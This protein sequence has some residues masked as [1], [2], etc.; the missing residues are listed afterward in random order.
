MKI[1][2]LLNKQGKLWLN[3]GSSY[4]VLEDYI[5][6]D[7]SIFLLMSPFYPLLKFMLKSGHRE[8]IERF[9]KIKASGVTMLRCNCLKPLPFPD[10]SVDH[11]LCSHF[12]EHVY[13]DEAIMILKDYKR[14][15]KKSGTLHIVV[16]DLAVLI[17]DYTQRKNGDISADVFIKTTLLSS[18]KSPSLLFRILEIVGRYGLKHLWM[19]DKDSLNSRLLGVGFNIISRNETPSSMFQRDGLHIAARRMFSKERKY[20]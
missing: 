20:G 3:I 17:S 7:N 5:N 4:N 9:R 8:V 12:L 16:P 19:Y 14:V 13:P 10:E 11:I 2:K 18:D 15:L 1:E 6:L